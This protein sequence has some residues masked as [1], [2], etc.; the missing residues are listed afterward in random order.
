MVKRSV[1]LC[2]GEYIGIESIYT[3]K[4]GKQINIPDKLEQLREKGRSGKL[5]CACGCGARLSVI[6]GDGNIRKQHFRVWP[7]EEKAGCRATE[8]GYI[9][10]W[11]KIVLKQWLEDK[12]GTEEI[13]CRVPVS[14]LFN[15]GREYQI[16]LLA[17]EQNV[18]ICYWYD[19][20]NLEDEKI[21]ILESNTAGIHVIYV[22]DYNNEQK[23]EQYPERMMKIQKQQEYCLFL[24]SEEEKYDCVQM[25]AVAYLQNE[26]GLWKEVYI[27][28][29]MLGDYDIESNGMLLFR[30][31][32][33]LELATD[34]KSL[35]N[36]QVELEIERRRKK[37]ERQ[38]SKE[39][40]E[41]EELA[42]IVAK[43]KELAASVEQRVAEYREQQRQKEARLGGKNVE[44]RDVFLN[45]EM[46]VTDLNIKRKMCPFCNSKVIERQRR[47]RRYVKCSNPKCT[48]EDYF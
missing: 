40:K 45:E 9:S 32:S 46:N 23:C 30:G 36:K 33:L 15:V 16:S 6:A 18:A 28:K 44:A 41:M 29:G 20:T 4:D 14:R 13:E 24:Y 11:S 1:C 42:R 21:E 38:R 26:D 12:L 35:F 5:L 8:E 34:K 39:E 27:A 7:G 31:I 2:D 19:R 48:F 25:K 43:Q 17:R 47:G 3:V 10:I 22:V 37:E